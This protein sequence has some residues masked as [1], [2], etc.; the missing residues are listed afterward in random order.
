MH[1]SKRVRLLITLNGTRHRPVH[2][3]HAPATR[4][5]DQQRVHE[6]TIAAGIDS[7]STFVR[8]DGGAAPTDAKRVPQCHPESVRL[9][10]F[11][12]GK[13]PGN[14]LGTIA[15]LAT[16]LQSGVATQP[17]A[18]AGRRQR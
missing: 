17:A 11:A 5:A 10:R 2:D 18:D 15:S 8:Q 1:D 4:Y 16:V 7:S 3:A 9:R 14:W 13:A 12:S 6:I